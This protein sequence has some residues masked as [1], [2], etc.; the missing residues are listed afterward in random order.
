MENY[1]VLHTMDPKTK[2][3]GC[4]CELW[5]FGLA[6]SSLTHRYNFCSSCFREITDRSNYERARKECRQREFW[7]DSEQDA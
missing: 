1:A 6:F 4:E 5:A 3:S 2:C 7:T